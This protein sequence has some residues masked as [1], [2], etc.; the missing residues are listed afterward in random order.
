[1]VELC[2]LHAFCF[3]ETGPDASQIAAVCDNGL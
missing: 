1:M 3:S 2:T